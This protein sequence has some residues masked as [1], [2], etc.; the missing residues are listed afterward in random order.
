MN[1]HLIYNAQILQ[2]LTNPN[3][4]H[5]IQTVDNPNLLTSSILKKC[6]Q[7]GV[8]VIIGENE[9]THTKLQQIINRS[10]CKKHR[11]KLK[12]QIDNQSKCKKYRQKLKK[13]T[14]QTAW[15]QKCRHNKKIKFSKNEYGSIW[16]NDHWPTV[17][18]AKS[19]EKNVNVAIATARAWTGNPQNLD[20]QPNYNDFCG[21]EQKMLDEWNEH[22]SHKRNHHT[23][24][25]CGIRNYFIPQTLPLTDSKFAIYKCLK[26][27]HSTTLHIH[28]N[29]NKH[30]K[31]ASEGIKKQIVTMCPPCYR[32]VNNQNKKIRSKRQL[33][34]ESIAFRDW[35][36][37]P[38][39]FP[40][41]TKLEKIVISKAIIFNQAVK[42][43]PDEVSQKT[44]RGHCIAISCE[45]PDHLHEQIYKAPFTFAK[46]FDITFIGQ[47]YQ[48][49]LIKNLIKNEDPLSIDFNKCMKWLKLLKQTHP[50]YHDIILPPT[51][52]EI[53]KLRKK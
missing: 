5:F 23:C 46:Y 44:L 36:R 49:N 13:R 50:E 16:E 53:K 38:K 20:R 10:K 43:V 19:L 27:K 25:V 29:K 3:F 22:H 2:S 41:L 17:K 35:G 40:L 15:Q 48:W 30:W 37:I 51:A 1:V 32:K 24:A 14:S 8:K 39:D 34:I 21:D 11:Q 28:S 9:L 26:P 47:K 4:T 7:N 45:S 52:K 12:K 33:H 42:I 6:N 31:L 18:Q